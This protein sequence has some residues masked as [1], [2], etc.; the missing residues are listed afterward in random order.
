MPRR[1]LSVWQVAVVLM[2]LLV[3]VLVGATGP[4]VAGLFF[5]W[6]VW[7]CVFDAVWGTLS[8]S[9][10]S[11]S[12][13]P[14]SSGAAEVSTGEN[15]PVVS[16]GAPSLH[17]EGAEEDLLPAAEEKRSALEPD[18][19]VRDTPEASGVTSPAHAMDTLLAE[20]DVVVTPG[21]GVV[22]ATLPDARADTPASPA[23]SEPAA[24][25]TT[26]A[27]T[28]DADAA[29]PTP[30][31][32]D[33]AASMLQEQRASEAPVEAVAPSPHAEPADTS[34]ASD[35]VESEREHVPA[36][37]EDPLAATDDPSV[38]LRDGAQGVDTA[39]A[40]ASAPA[41]AASSDQPTP[42]PPAPPAPAP[43]AGTAANP[44][45]DELAAPSAAGSEAEEDELPSPQEYK[46][47][48]LEKH[49]SKHFPPQPG[50]PLQPQATPQPQAHQQHH[51]QQVPLHD[52]AEG[53]AH[54]ASIHQEDE[55]MEVQH[56]NY[57]S[58]DAGAVLLRASPEVTGA[59]N[60]LES[61]ADK[62]LLFHSND[63]VMSF[64]VQLSE[65]VCVPTTFFALRC[66]WSDPVLTAVVGG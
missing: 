64:V 39:T 15:V 48:M 3:C 11:P 34:D 42:A 13:A 7:K 17:E 62:Y 6:S 18:V 41:P 35:P 47:N 25:A 22:D 23:T 20:G 53:A 31:S 5:V 51:H 56:V 12:A 63:K 30:S 16:V 26:S 58:K 43:H 46:K 57:A 32:H 38:P 45:G 60:L 21:D 24:S 29:V 1:H 40:A 19:A 54:E 9:E 49:F 36:T 10:D 14:L 61:N 52:D 33:Q 66:S 44:T 8:E 4:W 2:L 65:E 55:T 27:D 37:Q 50:A 28:A 59:S